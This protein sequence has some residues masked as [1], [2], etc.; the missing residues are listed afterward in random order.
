MKRF[1]FPV[2]IV[3]LLAAGCAS[4]PENL[5]RETA[6]VIGDISP[7]QVRVSNVKR[8]VTNVNWDADTP[9]G[10]Y[11]CSADDMVRRPYCNKK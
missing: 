2:I 6:R 5:Q 7:D 11:S 8:G 10:S 3:C 9:K 4:T 1:V